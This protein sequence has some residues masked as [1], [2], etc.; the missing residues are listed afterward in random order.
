M[1]MARPVAVGRLAS[2]HDDFVPLL[3]T[4]SAVDRDVQIASPARTYIVEGN[5]SGAILGLTPTR[6]ELPGPAQSI[7]WCGAP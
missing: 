3:D 6:A 4:E 5:A 7:P 1:S 2:A